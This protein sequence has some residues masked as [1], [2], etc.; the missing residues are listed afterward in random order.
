MKS[1][2]ERLYASAIWIHG[3]LLAM[4]AATPATAQVMDAVD[5]AWDLDFGQELVVDNPGVLDNDLLD[6]EAA[7]E[8]G[9]LAELVV[10][11]A[12]G[13]LVLNPDGSFTYTPDPD[14]DGFDSFVYAAVADT[15][16]D[17]ATVILNSCGG[18]PDVFFC[19]TEGGFQAMTTDRGYYTNFESFEDDAAWVAV[20]TPDSLPSVTNHGIRWTSN[21]PDAPVSNPIST[22]SGPPRTGMWAIFDPNHGY[23]EGTPT[24]CD[25]DSFPETCLYHDGF[26]GEV[27]PGVSPLVGVGGY[28]TGSF[29]ANVA[30]VINDTTLY[31]G[32]QISGYQ[33]FGVVD[34]RPAGFTK[35]EFREV[36]GKVGQAF[37]VFGDD[38]TFLTTAPPVV[39]AARDVGTRVFFAGAGPNPSGGATTWRYSLAGASHVA[40]SV[41]DARGRLVRRLAVGERGPGPHAIPWDGRDGRGR[42]V[43]AGTYFGRLTVDGGRGPEV[44]VRKV[45]VLH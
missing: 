35:F 39:S 16:S 25:V 20:R 2:I 37:F 36:D 3:L 1:S 42:H 4:F 8:M 21:Y 14:F 33:F 32:G 38:F 11:A 24:I 23:A 44:S 28:V 29:G 15:I 40:L 26:T 12:Q 31:P 19:W 34:T 7:F 18:G 30:I 6:G 5:D 41:Y 22:T 45:M 10:D 13:T 9:A 17:Q 43:A 27:E